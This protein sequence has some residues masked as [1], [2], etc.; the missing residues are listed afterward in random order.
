MSLLDLPCKQTIK[1]KPKIV[2]P[3][4]KTKKHTYLKQNQ[5]NLPEASAPTAS[6]SRKGSLHHGCSTHDLQRLPPFGSVHKWGF[7]QIRFLGMFFFFFQRCSSDSYGG[8]SKN[9]A[10]TCFCSR[11]LALPWVC[12]FCCFLMVV[13]VLIK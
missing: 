8:S 9:F 12:V 6:L 4:K 13:I 10:R 7:P 3:I 2:R 1:N 11:I 5:E